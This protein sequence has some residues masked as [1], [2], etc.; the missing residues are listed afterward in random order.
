MRICIGNPCAGGAR[1]S[2]LADIGEAFLD[3]AVSSEVHP[4]REANR[5]TCDRHRDEHT[6]LLALGEQTREVGQA[7][8]GLSAFIGQAD[9]AYALLRRQPEFLASWNVVPGR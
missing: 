7:W 3:D 5:C 6:R 8:C 9:A 4:G 1:G 2:V